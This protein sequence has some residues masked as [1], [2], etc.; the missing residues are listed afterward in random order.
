LL[1][2]GADLDAA[3]MVIN[4]SGEMRIFNNFLDRKKSF[5]CVTRFQ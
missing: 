4:F 5:G 1:E 3:D 2:S